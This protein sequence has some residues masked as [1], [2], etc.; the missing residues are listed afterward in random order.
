M[1]IC[2]TSLDLIERFFENRFQRVTLNDQA[3]QWLP[4]EAGSISEPIFFLIY[5]N[6][7]S[8]DIISTL[9]LFADDTSL[10]SIIY[11]AKTAYEL[12][13]NYQKIAEWA[14]Q[15]KMLF[16]PD[17]NKQAQELIFSKQKRLNH[18]SHKSFSTI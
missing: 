6:D 8:L 4:V 9:K 17:Q 13:K 2:D 10:F 3:S 14:H 18:F 11:D 1:I 7:L 15:Q 16:N 5:I 12:N